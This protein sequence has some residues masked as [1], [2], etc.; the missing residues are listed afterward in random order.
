MQ[1]ARNWRQFCLCCL[2]NDYRTAKCFDVSP[3]RVPDHDHGSPRQLS[4]FCASWQ[5]RGLDREGLIYRSAVK[6]GAAAQVG[7]R[8]TYKRW[9]CRRWRAPAL[10]GGPGAVDCPHV[11]LLGND[12]S[13]LPPVSQGRSSGGAL[14]PPPPLAATGPGPLAVRKETN[15]PSRFKLSN[16]PP[17]Q[18]RP[19]EQ[20]WAGACGGP[21]AR[22]WH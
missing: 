7:S 17:V 11:L 5:H 9:L 12:R 3:S 21:C 15:T 19:A 8:G 18:F 20:A 4:C 22:G 6:N 1:P 10:Q 13:R 2:P 16:L 14:P